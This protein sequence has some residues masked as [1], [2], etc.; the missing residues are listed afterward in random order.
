MKIKI[1]AKLNLSLYI[2][3]K[4]PD[5]LHNLDTVMVPVAIY[6]EVEV[7]PSDTITTEFHGPHSEGIDPLN[8]TAKKAA[9]LFLI[10]LS[11]RGVAA[12]ERK[13]RTADGVFDNILQNGAK[14][15]VYKGIPQKAGMGGS[16]AD[17][18]GV[19]RGLNSLYKVRLNRDKFCDMVA[20]CGDDVWPMLEMQR[21]RNRIFYRCDDMHKMLAMYP[22]DF[23]LFFII[24]P[25][26]YGVSTKDCFAVYNSATRHCDEPATK[27]SQPLNERLISS[28]QKSRP[29]NDLLHNDLFAP[30]V[31]LNP[32]I[33]DNYNLLKAHC[34]NV[35][36]TGSGSAVCAL[37]YNKKERDEIFKKISPLA[38]L[39]FTTHSI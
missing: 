13:A 33:L 2:T 38:P 11:E 16:S 20:E 30:A 14:I 31:S 21:L 32:K 3:G 18:A 25:E 29:L 24:L 10:P 12:A 4:R 22:L 9:E 39:A 1:P 27:Q 7:T 37:F 26:T 8:N 5:G 23:T 17:P 34:P 36:M 19:L 15:R 28:L 35:F 6:D